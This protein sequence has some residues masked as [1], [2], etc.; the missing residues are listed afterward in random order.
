M[1]PLIVI[2]AVWV[3]ST[4]FESWHDWTLHSTLYGP[5]AKPEDK[6]K[7]KTLDALEKSVFL[8]G[9]SMWVWGESGDI[10]LTGYVTIWQGLLRWVGHEAWYAWFSR[11]PFGTF[12]K[13]SF[14]DAAV[15]S[16]ELGRWGSVA[17][18]LLPTIGTT[19]LVIGQSLR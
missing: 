18:M 3:C 14:I 6:D 12:G 15:G 9:M 5:E 1:E 13:S 8:A 11:T 17:L 2:F 7:L 19:M 10:Y 4:F 16:L